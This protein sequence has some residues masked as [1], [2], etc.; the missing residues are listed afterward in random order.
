M[1]CPDTQFTDVPLLH[2]SLDSFFI[3]S[4]LSCLNLQ[5]LFSDHTARCCP[6]TSL[7]GGIAGIPAI[8]CFAH[9]PLSSSLTHRLGCWWFLPDVSQE[10]GTNL[11]DVQHCLVW[12]GCCKAQAPSPLPSCPATWP[13]AAHPWVACTGSLG[14]LASATQGEDSSVWVSKTKN[15]VPCFFSN[16]SLV[17]SGN[18]LS[19]SASVI[20]ICSATMAKVR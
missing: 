19:R 11:A 7:E 5:F 6:C 13:P 3:V 16:F 14:A 9:S 17:L 18:T 1:C 8:R 20:S 10:E 4:F 12:G 15:Q 2:W